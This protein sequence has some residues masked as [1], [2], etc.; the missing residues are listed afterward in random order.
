MRFS[1]W[2]VWTPQ[3][4]LLNE[5]DTGKHG[6]SDAQVVVQSNGSC[7]YDTD[8]Q[9]AAY[10]GM[11]HANWPFDYHA[12]Q[13]E[14]ET[15]VYNA[16]LF[17]TKYIHGSEMDPDF[18]SSEWEVKGIIFG[19]DRKKER[20]NALTLNIVV[21]RRTGGYLLTLF[22]P[23]TVFVLFTLCGFWLPVQAGEKILLNGFVGAMVNMYML[24]FA[25][26]L[27]TMGVNTPLVVKFCCITMFLTICSMII[28]ILVL[29]ISRT[30]HV[31]G[32]PWVI[33]R[34]VD[35]SFGQFMLLSFLFAKPVERS[36]GGTNFDVRIGRELRADDEEEEDNADDEEA[37]Y[38]EVSE[39]PSNR[40]S[41]ESVPKMRKNIQQDWISLAT[42]IDRIAFVLYSLVFILL[43]IVYQV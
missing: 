43:A 30:Q 27:P 19:P 26:K 10:C 41:V 17:K 29:A 3:L 8:M 21:A 11:D 23:V 22:A 38:A 24:Y 39:M 14:F 34:I 6:F 5:I 31:Y 25:G 9:L 36:E 18:I 28:S 32:T 33:K 20:L 16:A 13:F 15:R 37:E 42:L 40:G 2:R 4:D 35:S 12:C 7:S 1:H